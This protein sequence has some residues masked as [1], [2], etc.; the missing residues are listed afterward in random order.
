MTLPDSRS[1]V[2]EVP[3]FS[4]GRTLRLRFSNTDGGRF[5]L[6]GGV[7]LELGMRRRTE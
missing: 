3:L 6:E 1:E 2:A 4:S 5:T 7:E